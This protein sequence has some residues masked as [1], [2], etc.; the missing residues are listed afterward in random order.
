VGFKK[1]KLS[2]NGTHPVRPLLR[3]STPPVEGIFRGAAHASR[4]GLHRHSRA[5]GNPEA[6]QPDRHNK[7][8]KMQHDPF[9]GFNNMQRFSEETITPLY[10]ES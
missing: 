8:M 6:G 2:L 4:L 7:T 9:N 1:E 10:V 5:S 3:A